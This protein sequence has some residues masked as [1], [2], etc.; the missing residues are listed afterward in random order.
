L[1]KRKEQLTAV[2]SV[3]LSSTVRC[4]HTSYTTTRHDA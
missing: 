4:K 1:E 3:K 2:I